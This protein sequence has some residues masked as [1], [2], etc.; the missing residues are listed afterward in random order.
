MIVKVSQL[1][2]LD[3]SRYCAKTA[4]NLHASDIGSGELNTSPNLGAHF[5]VVSVQSAAIN[6]MMQFL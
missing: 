5:P 6:L 3:N 4:F 2:D 1:R